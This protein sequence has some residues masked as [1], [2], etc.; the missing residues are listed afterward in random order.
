MAGAIQSSAAP[1]IAATIIVIVAIAAPEKLVFAR[2]AVK[3]PVRARPARHSL[4]MIVV[5]L[6]PVSSAFAETPAVVYEGQAKLV[7]QAAEPTASRRLRAETAFATT[8]AENPAEN[9]ASVMTLR[10]PLQTL[11]S[12]CFA[13]ASEGDAACFRAAVEIDV[14]FRRAPITRMLDPTNAFGVFKTR[15]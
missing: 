11:G 5:S 8:V 9:A 12:P 1:F 6:L 10:L 2:F 14:I 4:F 15:A 7:L 13:R 3:P